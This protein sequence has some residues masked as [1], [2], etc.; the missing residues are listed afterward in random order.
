M[1]SKIVFM[2][3]AAAYGAGVAAGAGGWALL[4]KGVYDVVEPGAPVDTGGPVKAYRVRGFHEKPDP[5]TA[6]RWS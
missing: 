1:A 2:T 5:A 3:C 6:K 4:A